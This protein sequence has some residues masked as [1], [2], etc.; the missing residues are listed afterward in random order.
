MGLRPERLRRSLELTIILILL[1]KGRSIGIKNN[2][3]GAK[4]IQNNSGHRPGNGR[5]GVWAGPMYRKSAGFGGDGC[6][7]AAYPGG[8]L[9]PVEADPAE[10]KGADR[11]VWPT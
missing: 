2:L 7:E 4:A 3:P 10:G 8:Q 9:H 1:F 5:D 6:S 11:S